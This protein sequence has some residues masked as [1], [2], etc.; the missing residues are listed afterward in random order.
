[1]FIGS[2]ITVRPVT[3]KMWILVEPLRYIGARE[4]F[5]V[6]AGYM[7]DFASVP[8]VTAWLIPSYGLY[9]RAAILHDYLLTDVLSTVRVSSRDADGLFRRAMGELGVPPVKRWLMWTGVRWGALFNRRRRAGWWRSAPGVLA[10]SAPAAVVL[11]LPVAMVTLAL[12]VYGVVEWV[13]TCGRS[14]GTV[15]T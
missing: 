7:T 1:M 13:A 12:I 4:E 14:A 2:R 5:T 9:T 15:K 10:I 8:R 11:L 3:G 6:P